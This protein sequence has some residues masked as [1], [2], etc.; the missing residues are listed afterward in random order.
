VRVMRRG[1]LVRTPSF[2]LRVAAQ[3]AVSC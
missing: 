2:E 1:S 3:L